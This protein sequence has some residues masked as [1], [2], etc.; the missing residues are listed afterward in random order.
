MIKKKM[1]KKKFNK[2]KIYTKIIIN[3]CKKKAV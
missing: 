2:F 1:K 3:Y